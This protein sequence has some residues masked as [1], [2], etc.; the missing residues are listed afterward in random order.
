MLCY[1]PNLHFVLNLF[2]LHR[3]LDSSLMQL[4]QLV[5][6]DL[7]KCMELSIPIYSEFPLEQKRE[8]FANGSRDLK[9]GPT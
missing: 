8:L 1:E 4:G 3:L 6:S 5:V 7:R 9:F 2:V